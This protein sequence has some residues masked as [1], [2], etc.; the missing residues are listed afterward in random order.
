M[1]VFLIFEVD[2]SRFAACSERRA[3][4]DGLKDRGQQLL[5]FNGESD[6]SLE[7]RRK[8]V[9]EEVYSEL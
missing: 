9:W 6:N 8:V 4:L 1:R 5:G 3:I 7:G 2:G